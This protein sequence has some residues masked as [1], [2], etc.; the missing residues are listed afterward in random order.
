[1]GLK[2]M[3]LILLLLLFAVLEAAAPPE[4]AAE[5]A[6]PAGSPF[7]V[8]TDHVSLAVCTG[9]A[10]PPG[11]VDAAATDAAMGIIPNYGLVTKNV[12]F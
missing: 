8:V 3:L 1:M 9:A 10:A 6:D 11:A 7:A 2:L 5:V 12:Y 4:A